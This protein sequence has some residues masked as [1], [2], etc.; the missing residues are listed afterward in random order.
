MPLSSAN[1]ASPA[2]T[3][4]AAQTIC[5][6]GPPATLENALPQAPTN[7]QPALASCAGEVLGRS[8]LSDRDATI[9]L[10]VTLLAHVI[11][12]IQH[13]RVIYAA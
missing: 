12:L 9:A 1:M 13:V 10:L 8:G 11:L 3:A 5:A 6:V 2:D 4:Y 7:Q